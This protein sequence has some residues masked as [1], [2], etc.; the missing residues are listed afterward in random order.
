MFEGPQNLEGLSPEEMARKRAY[1]GVRPSFTAPT[2]PV[3][4]RE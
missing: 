3:G 4:M 2:Y 1:D